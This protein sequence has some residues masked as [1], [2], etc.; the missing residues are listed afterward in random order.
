MTRALLAAVLVVSANAASAT[1][2]CTTASLFAGNPTF[3]DGTA[4]PDEGAGVLED[5]PLQ[6]RTLNFKDNYLVTTVGQEIWFTDLSAP[7]PVLKRLAGKQ[8]AAQQWVSGPCASARFSNIWGLTFLK[9]GSIVLADPMALGLA[10]ITDPFGPKCTVS[11]LAGQVKDTKGAFQDAKKVTG[12][13]DGP[14]A[15]ARFT[16]VK[17][18]VAGDD[19]SVYFID[20]DKKLKKLANDDAHTVSTV[21]KTS[22]D[23]VHGMTWLNGK[24]YYLGHATD[25][26]FNEVD[27]ATGATREILKGRADQFGGLSSDALALSGLATDGTGFYTMF[28]GAI[29]YLTTDGKPKQVAAKGGTPFSFPGSYDPKAPHKAADLVLIG[30]QRHNIAGSN[31]FLAYRDGSLY[32]SSK[33]GTSYVT[34]IDCK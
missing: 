21:T 19:D 33:V 27:P 13:V 3:A 23:W 17:F 34:K 12:D 11:F 20:A 32:V 1:P 9:D 29:Y 15:S 22:G 28:R 18:P 6:W 4:K 14:G 24:I 25:L 5:P 2:V 31:N 16:S 30:L 26:F 7:K 10:K 8:E